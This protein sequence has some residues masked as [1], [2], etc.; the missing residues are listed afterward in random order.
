MNRAQRRAAG[1]NGADEETIPLLTMTQEQLEQN[2][3]HL[4]DGDVV[5]VNGRRWKDGQIEH[6]AAG[7]ET[8]F[9]IRVVAATAKP[10]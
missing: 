10:H 5:R 2:M 9:R 6:C 8:P 4:S 1:I 3:P 7:E